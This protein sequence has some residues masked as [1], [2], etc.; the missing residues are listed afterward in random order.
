MRKVV[1]AEYLSLDGVVEDPGRIGAFEHR[2]WIIPYYDDELA[3]YMLDQLLASDALLLGRTTYEG[4]LTTWPSRA[5]DPIA[6]R[7]NSLPKMVASTTLA[8]PLAW[9]ASLLSDDVAEEVRKLKQQPGRDLLIYG[10]QTLVHTLMQRDLIDVFQ[11]M[12]VPLFL[13][14]GKRFFD[15]GRDPTTLSLTDA[16][17][18][19]AGVVMLTYRRT[20]NDGHHRSTAVDGI[21]GDWWSGRTRSSGPEVIGSRALSPP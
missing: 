20:A 7:M 9:N 4:F 17:T 3:A 15:E 14:S 21:G 13:G 10:S 11:L 8:E 18:T 16:R 12:I 19:G 5:G 6:D 2:G 1:V